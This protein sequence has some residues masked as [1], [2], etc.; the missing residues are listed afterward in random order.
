[1]RAAKISKGGSLLRAYQ[2]KAMKTSLFVT[3]TVAAA[4]IVTQVWAADACLQRNRLQSW[5]AVDNSTM[6]MT[7]LQQNRYTVH[8]K[9]ACT[10]LDRPAAKLVYRTWENLACLQSGDIIG[11]TAPGLGLVTCSVAGVEAGVPG[12]APAQ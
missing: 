1:M 10:N 8:M 7:D 11:V 6:V 5:R 2:E 9:G 12:A 4:T 3:S